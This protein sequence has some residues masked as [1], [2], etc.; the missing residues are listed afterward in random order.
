MSTEL[1]D[2]QTV[3]ESQ[4]GKRAEEHLPGAHRQGYTVRMSLLR[5]D[6]FGTKNVTDME[7][8]TDK[9][10]SSVSSF[11]HASKTSKVSEKTTN[12]NIGQKN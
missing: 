1:C 9:N 8:V 2:L 3:C 11:P 6:R 10:E 4:L 7:R 12:S 5:F